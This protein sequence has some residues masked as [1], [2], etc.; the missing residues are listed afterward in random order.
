MVVDNLEEI[1]YTYMPFNNILDKKMMYGKTDLQYLEEGKN[2]LE[3]FESNKKKLKNQSKEFVE[4]INKSETNFINFVNH[5]KETWINYLD[6]INYSN[7][8][9]QNLTN[10]YPE[11]I[12]LL[13]N[14]V[15]SM[16]KINSQLYF[17][18]DVEKEI[19]EHAMNKLDGERYARLIE[20]VNSFPTYVSSLLKNNM[21]IIKNNYSINNIL[22]QSNDLKKLFEANGFS[23]EM[24]GNSIDGLT[25]L[26]VDKLT[27]NE[28]MPKNKF[29]S[30]LK[31]ILFMD[32]FLELFLRKSGI[33]M[34]DLKFYVNM[35]NKISSKLKVSE[36]LKK[37][38]SEYERTKNSLK[39]KLPNYTQ[40][41]LSC[42]AV[43][44]ANVVGTY[45]PNI[46][47]DRNL[48][49]SILKK[50]SVRGY[51]NNIP[52]SIAK[53]S[54][55][56]FGIFAKMF[57]E[58]KSFKPLFM[59]TK[60]NTP[61]LKKFRQD[62]NK[63]DL[64]DCEGL[65]ADSIYK[66]IESGNLISYVSGSSPMLHYKLI[67]GYNLDKNLFYVF[68]PASGC[69][70]MKEEELIRD[71]RNDKSVWGVE[72]IPP[73]KEIFEK[74]RSSIFNANKNIERLTNLKK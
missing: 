27:I 59:D 42:G 46:I 62:L 15:D 28:F 68:D 45:Y 9:S 37:L 24:L 20:S 48:E 10:L 70:K 61:V 65:N 23:L 54:K 50:V 4:H 40:K 6:L 38:E 8:L 72:Y 16:F 57:A 2:I 58:L 11:K 52:S 5:L 55:E 53:V 33:L 60:P 49:K 30:S 29:E 21:K 39:I 67:H 1:I 34:E 44:L 31:E 51:F 7:I 12:D 19:Y 71:L 66:K 41:E 74:V 22:S 35:G 13:K 56:N 32:H 64:E 14:L 36:I 43:C 25:G 26:D 73:E 63:I 47:V 17:I 18:T 3:E 69:I